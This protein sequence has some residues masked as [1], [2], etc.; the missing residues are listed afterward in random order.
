[1]ALRCAS[2]ARFVALTSNQQQY[3]TVQINANIIVQRI[4]QPLNAVLPLQPPLQTVAPGE[5]WLLALLLA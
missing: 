4:A 5:S 1:M 2:A 3:Y